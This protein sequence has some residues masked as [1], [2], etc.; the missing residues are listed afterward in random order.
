MINYKLFLFLKQNILSI[1]SCA[2]LLYIETV[3]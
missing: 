1:L 2:Y 3:A